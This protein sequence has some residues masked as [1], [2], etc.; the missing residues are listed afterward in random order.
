MMIPYESGVHDDYRPQTFS[1]TMLP[2]LGEK[3]GRQGVRDS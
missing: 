2:V 1:K 3:T